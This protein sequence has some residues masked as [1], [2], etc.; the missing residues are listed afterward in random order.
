MS[1]GIFFNKKHLFFHPTHAS[2]RGI[3]WAIAVVIALVGLSYSNSLEAIWTLDDNPNIL[4]NPRVQIDNL[5]WGI[6][7][8]S[9]FSP[10]HTNTDGSYRINRPVAHLSFALNW[11]FGGSSPVGYRLVNISIHCLTA[12]LLFLV[13][14][15][16]LGSP[17]ME[18]RHTGS[19]TWI[20]LSAALLWALNPIQTQAVTYIVQRMTSLM[21]LFYIAS[22]WFY[23]LARSQGWRSWRLYSLSAISGLLALG[24]KE[25]AVMLPVVLLVADVVFYQ[26]LSQHSARRRLYTVTGC[27]ACILMLF[28]FW[29][30]GRDDIEVMLGYSGR[31]F[32]LNERLMTEARIVWLYLS[33][34]AYPIPTRISIV[35]DIELSRSLLDPW[36]TLPAVLFLAFAVVFALWQARKRPFLG[37]AVLFFM[38]NH[39]IESSILGLELIFEHRNYLPSL[40]LFVPAAMGARWALAQTQPHSR[41]LLRVG[42]A[43]VILGFGAGTWIRNLAWADARTFWSDAAGKAP[44]SMRPVAN[45]AY[46]YYERIGDYRRAFE[47]YHQA[48]EL[49]DYNRMTVSLL[50]VNIACLYNF[51]GVFSRANEHIETALA[52]APEFDQ[53]RNQQALILC[54]AGK[55]ADA[56]ATILPLVEKRPHSPDYR[57]TLGYILLK[58]GRIAEALSELETTLKIAPKAPK[59]LSLTGIGASL[60]GDYARAERLLNLALQAVP[61]DKRVLLWM[62]DLKLRMQDSAAA[63]RF[64]ARFLSDLQSDQVETAVASS[65]REGLMPESSRSALSAWI[66]SQAHAEL[67]S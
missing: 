61:N 58:Y 65:L 51:A 48:L 9:F 54:D 33:Q 53:A 22:F 35:H 31:L 29:P 57:Y 66:R 39:L 43:L 5:H 21:T 46:E 37:F 15:A 47:L 6:L 3:L 30:F 13:I 36:T 19:K 8:Q 25:N 34:L 17:N 40:F 45:L 55:L 52:L 38:I 10:Q 64:T 24:S 60:G 18:G 56:Y 12:S 14:H 23:I 16:L 67:N 62:T 26:D 63:G 2:R 28:A 42:F 7:Y 4:N 20:A 49:Q 59:L 44:R 11:Y 41:L 32:S 50:H 27:V 1:P